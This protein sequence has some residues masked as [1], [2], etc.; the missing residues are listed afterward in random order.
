M[1]LLLEDLYE[2]AQDPKGVPWGLRL[3][4]ARLREL[5]HGSEV[6]GL[7]HG[8]NLSLEPEAILATLHLVTHLRTLPDDYTKLCDALETLIN[9]PRTWSWQWGERNYQ[10]KTFA[11]ARWAIDARIHLQ[12]LHEMA[13]RSMQRRRAYT[14]TP[15]TDHI[16]T[17]NTPQTFTHCVTLALENPQGAEVMQALWR[18]IR[19]FSEHRDALEANM[20]QQVQACA[21]DPSLTAEPRL[22]ALRQLH[23]QAKQQPTH[24]KALDQTLASMITQLG[25]PWTDV[26]LKRMAPAT[27]LEIAPRT[28]DHLQAEGVLKIK[29]LP[30]PITCVSRWGRVHEAR[31]KEVAHSQDWRKTLCLI[32]NGTIKQRITALALAPHLSSRCSWQEVAQTL[33]DAIPTTD[34]WNPPGSLSQNHH[35]DIGLF[36][37]HR[38]TRTLESPLRKANAEAM[39]MLH[40]GITAL[41]RRQSPSFRHLPML[42]QRFLDALRPCPAEAVLQWRKDLLTLANNPHLDAATRMAALFLDGRPEA[43]D[44]AFKFILDPEEDQA[45][46]ALLGLWLH[47][48]DRSKLESLA[49]S[50]RAPWGLAE[51]GRRDLPICQPGR[52]LPLPWILSSLHGHNLVQAVAV[53]NLGTRLMQAYHD[54]KHGELAQQLRQELT[55]EITDTIRSLTD[56]PHPDAPRWGAV[57]TLALLGDPCDEDRLWGYMSQ[58]G[59]WTSLDPSQDD[60]RAKPMVEHLVLQPLEGVTAHHLLEPFLVIGFGQT[61]A[62]R[63]LARAFAAMAEQAL[64]QG[65]LAQVHRASAHITRL[66]PWNLA[67]HRLKRALGL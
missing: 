45:L 21:L 22:Q 20:T 27:L 48:W 53:R 31:T 12:N 39:A 64:Q 8:C 40:Q 47:R 42:L 55:P 25:A 29:P 58:H 7:I 43:V 34:H 15:C 35:L 36:A 57:L 2:V 52:E 4:F 28:T 67:G 6:E 32:T 46:R 10:N 26:R 54:G 60:L 56:N 59:P 5:A 30:E 13:W 49:Q 62:Q 9:D 14:L 23:W 66:D 37:A 44:A 17:P 3:H 51:T 33:L 61:H 65:R 24:K 16:E 19:K 18:S 38:L 1:S 63:I 11:V 50:D 41:F